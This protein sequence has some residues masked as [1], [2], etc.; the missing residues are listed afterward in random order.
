MSSLDTFRLEVKTTYEYIP[1]TTFKIWG[2][3]D[4]ARSTN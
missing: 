1:T 4:N 2:S 3:C